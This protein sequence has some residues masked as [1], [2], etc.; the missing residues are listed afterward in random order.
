MSQILFVSK[1]RNVCIK[2]LAPREFSSG[3]PGTTVI[4]IFNAYNRIQKRD[5]R[6]KIYLSI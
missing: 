1:K 5:N 3:T 2:Y 4:Q 6:I